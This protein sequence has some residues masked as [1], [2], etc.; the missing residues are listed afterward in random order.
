[1]STENEN[2]RE[3]RFI[4][5]TPGGATSKPLSWNNNFVKAVKREAILRD[6]AEVQSF[7]EELVRKSDFDRLVR[8][9][10]DYDFRVYRIYHEQ[11]TE[12]IR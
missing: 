12:G 7:S 2:A 10:E 8:I 1:M 6:L 11:P 5:A 4:Y 3:N 9:M